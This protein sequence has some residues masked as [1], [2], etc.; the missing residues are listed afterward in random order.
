MQFL[1]LRRGTDLGRDS[2]SLET[3]YPIVYNRFPQECFNKSL[4]NVCYTSFKQK[5]YG[6]PDVALA[7]SGFFNK[8][9]RRF[10]WNTKPTVHPLVFCSK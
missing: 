7:K 2:P 8:T 4:R 6:L 5:L 10:I 1:G 9:H 3:T